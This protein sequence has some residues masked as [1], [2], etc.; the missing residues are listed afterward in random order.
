MNGA[1]TKP[2]RS[3]FRGSLVAIVTPFRDGEVDFEAFRKLVEWHVESGT[4]GLVVAGTTG[5]GA[6]LD[7]GERTRLFSAAVEIA[8]G[9]MP[10]L[11]G[12]GTN[13]TRTTI[14]NARE[15][16]ACGVDGLLVVT[17]YYNRP[18]PRGL[19]LHF[20]AVAEAARTP[21][22]LYNVPSR[23]SV[24]MVPEVVAELAARF[25]HVVAVKEALPSLERVKRL[26][27]ETQAD[28]LCGDDGSIADFMGLGAVG[29]IG[30][31]NNVVPRKVAALVRA[32]APGGDTA[33]AANLVEE[34]APL[35]RDLFLETN[36]G[37]VKAA[38]AMLGRCR[39]ELRLPLAPMIESNRKK[40]EATVRDFARE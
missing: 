39:D 15:A 30:V 18:T 17:P 29:V 19:L 23:T 9:R 36:P 32:A 10:V 40:L 37:P 27:G 24:D 12:I 14:E 8:R 38:L 2:R 28:V 6:T 35:V 20:S 5:E 13:S 4:D 1:A 22:V 26:L 11:A 7:G 31:V 3:R 16:E 21:I 34:I 33:R 25:P